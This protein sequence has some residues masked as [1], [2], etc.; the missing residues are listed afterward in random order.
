LPIFLLAENIL[1]ADP[2][3]PPIAIKRHK[4]IPE[5]RLNKLVFIRRDPVEAILSH[6]TRAGEASERDLEAGVEWWQHLD[7]MYDAWPKE[8]RLLIDFEHIFLGH[9]QWIKELADFLDVAASAKKV[10]ACAELISE[11]KKILPRKP[12]TTALDTYRSR[13]PKQAT[14]LETLLTKELRG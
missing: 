3:D 14:I 12:L 4:I 6:T 5:D 2:L 1:A 8:T 9:T 10:Q 13:Y 7:D 11:A